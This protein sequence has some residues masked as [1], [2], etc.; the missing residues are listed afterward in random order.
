MLEVSAGKLRNP[1]A[2][3]VLMVIDDGLFHRLDRSL[4]KGHHRH[5]RFPP[6]VAVKGGDPRWEC[7]LRKHPDS[8]AK[9]MHRQ[10]KLAGVTLY[11]I[12]ATQ[13]RE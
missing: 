5:G 9:R 6:R 1:V 3:I 13:A 12:Q 4:D 11:V 2:R 7:G 10:D 8:R